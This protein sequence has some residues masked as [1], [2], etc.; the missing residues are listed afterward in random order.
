MADRDEK[1]FDHYHAAA[2]SG[3]KVANNLENLRLMLTALYTSG[4]GSGLMSWAEADREL[5]LDMLL[6]AAEGR[7]F[8]PVPSPWPRGRDEDKEIAYQLSRYADQFQNDRPELA[9]KFRDIARDLTNG[10]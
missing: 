5:F 10:V 2:D 9:A 8:I 3:G 4:S 1:A 6:D 7:D